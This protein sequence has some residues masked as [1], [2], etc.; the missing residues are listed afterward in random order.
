MS[1]KLLL[2]SAL[3]INCLVFTGCYDKQRAEMAPKEVNFLGIV[4]T[5]EA[6]YEYTD[7]STAAIHTDELFARK[8]YSGRKTEFLWGLITIK[9]Y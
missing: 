7:A 5:E 8:N 4:S 2:I 3:L 6:S 9:D 1:S